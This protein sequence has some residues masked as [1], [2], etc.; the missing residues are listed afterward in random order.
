MKAPSLWASL[1]VIAFCGLL[2]GCSSSALG[3]AART[4]TGYASHVLCDDV[5]LGGQDPLVA[6][7]ERISSMP[8]MRPVVWTMRR[9]F[10]PVR[11]E[12]T[13][14]LAGQFAS[15]ARRLDDLGCVSLPEDDWR[16]FDPAPAERTTAS[17]S[18]SASTPALALLVDAPEAPA[19]EPPTSAMREALVRAIPDEAATAARHRT[20]AVVVMQAGRIVAERY[21]TGYGVDTPVLGYSATKSVTN[22]ML[23][24]LVRQG[25]LTLDRPAAFA[26]WSDPNDPR[27]TITVEQLLRQVSGLDLRQDNSGFDITG[28]VM[29]TVRDKA[30]AAMARPLVAAPGTRWQYSDLHFILL[31]RLVRDA[32]GG[33]AA[34][35]RRFLRDEL[36]A[37]LGMRHASIDFDVTG[38]PLGSS[39]MLASAR[40]W[41]RLGQL[42]LDDGIAPGGRRVLPEGWVAA[43]ARPTLDTGYG[44]GWWTNR[45]PGDV[46]GWHVPWGLA[47]APADA[48]FAR[49]FMGQY[50]VVVP[51]ERLVIVRLS[52]S[53]ARGDDI[54][55]TDRIVGDVRAALAR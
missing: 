37:P 32:V 51:S 12:V 31:S 55:E 39:F 52:V 54:E 21:A 1:T 38:T 11:H 18:Q 40:D 20:K 24:I 9:A 36:F 23:G 22:A 43:A 45:V 30:A 28:Q 13:V 49:G 41:A 53:Q 17:T 19:L 27:R 4:A 3:D 14:S 2:T 6:Y 35:V 33:N 48:F 29:Q 25:K 26:A 5:Y 34:S 42:Y 16:A 44:A 8:A 46:P 50:V 7:E 47:H 10:D 15:R